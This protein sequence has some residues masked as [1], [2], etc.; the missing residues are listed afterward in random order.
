MPFG[1]FGKLP[2]KRDFIAHN[3]A[4]AVL[5]PFEAWL[6]QAVA[7]SRA[8]L[9]DRWLDFYLHAPLWRFHLGRDILGR[10]AAG[11][12]MPSVDAVGRYFPLA[13]LYVAEAGEEIAPPTHDPAD[14][15]F[16]AIEARL[17]DVLATEEKIEPPALIDGL[18]PRAIAARPP[19][20]FPERHRNGLFWRSSADAAS[21]LAA[22]GPAESWIAAS[23][24][25]IWWAAPVGGGAAVFVSPGLPQPACFAEMIRTRIA[26]S[27]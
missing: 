20:P 18:P 11:V 19:E 22:I 6:Q 13:I 1:A 2:Q 9:G 21:L 15:W 12:V 14:A 24:K 8:E 16:E 27:A 23:A 3:L 10:T 5:E 25:S 17:L 26:P 4:R 7:A